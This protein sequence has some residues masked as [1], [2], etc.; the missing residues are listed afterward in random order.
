MQRAKAATDAFAAWLDAQA[1]SKTAPSGVGVENYDWY[2]KN[3]QL[4]PY[5]WQDEVTLMERELARAHAF[6]ALEEQRNAAL[7]A[8]VPIASAD[9]FTRAG[10]AM[11]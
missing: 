4:L 9:E 5:T 2:L 1:P 11:L 6:L 7:P 8:Q 3:V 10:S